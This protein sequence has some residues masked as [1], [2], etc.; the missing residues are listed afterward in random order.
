MLTPCRSSA[1]RAPRQLLLFSR[2]GKLFAFQATCL[3]LPAALDEEVAE[4]ET[5]AAEQVVLEVDQI[6]L[7]LKFL[8]MR[9]PELSFLDIGLDTEVRHDGVTVGL[10]ER[11]DHRAV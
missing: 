5:F 8:F 11:F 9:D 4:R 10:Q 3:R 6:Q 7:V 1:K 2:D